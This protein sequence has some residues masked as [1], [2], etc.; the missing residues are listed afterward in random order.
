MKNCTKC[1][2]YKEL[3][4]FGKQSKTKDSL[5]TYCKDCI[6]SNRKQNYQ[7]NK[8][9]EYEYHKQYKKDNPNKFKKYKSDYYLKNKEIINIK[10]KEYVKNNRKNIN[11]TIRKRNKIRLKKDPSFK[12]KRNI[13][14]RLYYAL[15]RKN[16][17]KNTLFSEYIGC[18]KDE[19]ITHFEK[20]FNYN[21]TWHNYGELWHIDHIVP[22]CLAKTDVEVYKLC[23]Y[24][25]LQ[26]LLI[27]EHKIKTANDISN[28]RN[29]KK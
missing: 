2:K 24:N 11:Y 28:Y 25:N 19:L 29:V 14:N 4:Y 13:R 15:K 3:I 9:R 23:H 21:M 20:Q 6:N 1:L 17:K 18:S 5:T 7:N 16:W 10:S 27:V 26:A 8:K 12:L 22:L